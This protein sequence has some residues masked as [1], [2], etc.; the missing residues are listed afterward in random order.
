MARWRDINCYALQLLLW[1]KWPPFLLKCP[2]PYTCDLE[3][4]LETATD[5]VAFTCGWVMLSATTCFMATIQ[6]LPLI[7][8]SLSF[9]RSLCER[10]ALSLYHSSIR[11]PHLKTKCHRYIFYCSVAP[12]FSKPCCI[13]HGL[14]F[15]S[16]LLAFHK[17]IITQ[18]LTFPFIM[19]IKLV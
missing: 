19:W 10:C 14:V 13:Q 1:M 16:C 6:C 17:R 7:A 8:Y 9:S 11:V 15:L 2:R 18:M 3:W 12:S 5:D 4:D